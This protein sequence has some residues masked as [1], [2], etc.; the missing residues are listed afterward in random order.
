MAE[1]QRVAGIG[2]DRARELLRPG[3]T[4]HEIEPELTVSLWWPIG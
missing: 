3:V 4:A 1:A 2:M